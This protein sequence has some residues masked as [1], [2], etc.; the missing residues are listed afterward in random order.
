MYSIMEALH[1]VLILI[2]IPSM[3]LGRVGLNGSNALFCSVVTS[4]E[5]VGP[6]AQID[7]NAGT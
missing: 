4:H 3:P 6:P 1:N 5:T 2:G 7:G